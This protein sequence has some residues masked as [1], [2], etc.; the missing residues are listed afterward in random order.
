MEPQAEGVHLD[1]CTRGGEVT[2]N[3]AS[4]CDTALPQAVLMRRRHRSGA[5]RFAMGLKADSKGAQS[6]D[7][8]LRDDA[9]PLPC[10]GALR[11]KVST[12]PA[13]RHNG[14]SRR[15]DQP[16]QYAVVQAMQGV[17]P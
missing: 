14:T 8:A 15:S 5:A 4:R 13:R 6:D 16:V 17:P 3:G 11:P 12:A 10:A 1:P 2:L 9:L 7:D